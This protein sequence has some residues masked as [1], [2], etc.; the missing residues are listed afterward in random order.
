MAYMNQAKK[1]I[2]AKNLKPILD[3]Y[4]VKGSLRVRNNHAI[5][6]TLRHGSIDFLSDMNDILY[7][8]QLDKDELRRRYNFAINQFW[9]QEHYNGE[10]YHFIK[11]V[12]EAMESADWYDRSDIQTDYFDT[13]YYY[14]ITVGSWD[15][16]YTV[17]R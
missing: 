5:T 7:G 2:I 16:P 4:R 8:K 9:Y 6:L 3:K 15:A 13:A 14:D 11:A 17:T 12:K 1:A 10:A